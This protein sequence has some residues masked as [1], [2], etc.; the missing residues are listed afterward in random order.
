MS[1]VAAAI[2][3]VPARGWNP[4]SSHRGHRVVSSSRAPIAVAEESV[5]TSARTI[6]PASA[7]LD[8]LGAEAIPDP[9]TAGDYCRR[10]S[11]PEIERL[12]DITNEVR[13]EVW[14]RQGPEFTRETARIDEIGRAHV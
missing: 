12:M 4:G 2:H 5:V 1:A 6:E 8:A 3:G 10:F 11:E 14:S 9:S 13:L 7:L